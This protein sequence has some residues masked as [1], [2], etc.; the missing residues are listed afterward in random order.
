MQIPMENLDPGRWY[1]GFVWKN[2][3][4]TGVL[5]M[6]WDGKLFR[7][8]DYAMSYR[9]YGTGM[10]GFEPSMP[11]LPPEPPAHILEKAS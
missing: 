10:D 6:E 11:D 4:Q 7:N 5:S 1:I 8:G 2:G 3:R 9:E